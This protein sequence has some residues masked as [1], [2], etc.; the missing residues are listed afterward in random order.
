[1]SSED[2]NI[3]KI[4]L[5]TTNIGWCYSACS[6]TPFIGIQKQTCYCISDKSD[7]RIRELNCNHGC[8][9]SSNA[10]CGGDNVTSLYRM[11]SHNDSVHFPE[12][13]KS[14]NNCLKMYLDKNNGSKSY[15]WKSCSEQ[16]WA[17]CK[18]DSDH[19]CELYRELKSWR[20]AAT[21]CFQNNGYP[22]GYEAARNVTYMARYGWTGIVW[23]DVIFKETELYRKNMSDISHGYLKYEGS[24]GYVLHFSKH[25]DERKYILCNGSIFL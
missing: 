4:Q 2:L 15:E 21:L 14:K 6:K 10:T 25:D 18:S 8:E 7:K 5:G 16:M 3:I 12:K 13:Q 24:L 20:N 1:M 11:L 17:F 19:S 23:S 9:V 22:I